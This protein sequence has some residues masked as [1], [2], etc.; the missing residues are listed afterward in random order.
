[1]QKKDLKL[2]IRF[3]SE[4]PSLTPIKVKDHTGATIEYILLSFPLYLVGQIHR[5]INDYLST[6]K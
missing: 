4:P 2:A 5:L 1:M 3:N 6:E